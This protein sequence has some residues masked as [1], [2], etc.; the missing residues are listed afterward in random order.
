MC[1]LLL[2]KYYKCFLA[3]C[4]YFVFLCGPIRFFAPFLRVFLTCYDIFLVYSQLIFVFF[5]TNASMMLKKLTNTKKFG[6]DIVVSGAR[7][8]QR[9]KT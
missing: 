2:Q 9:V 8:K 5:L 3:K 6:N 1:L 4:Q 7:E